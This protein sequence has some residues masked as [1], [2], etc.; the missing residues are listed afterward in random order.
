MIR[1]KLFENFKNLTIFK[2][3][4]IIKNYLIVYLGFFDFFKFS[5]CYYI[6]YLSTIILFE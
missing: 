5:F 3:S 1:T 6:L 4:Q 2:Y